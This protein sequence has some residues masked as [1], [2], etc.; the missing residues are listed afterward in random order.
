MAAAV[1]SDYLFISHANEDAVFADWLARKLMSE[2][3]RVWYDRLKL[4]G[5]E[6]YPAN[7][8]TA[9]KERS[10]R[11]LALLSAASLG[12]PNPTKERTLALNISRE[13]R[14]D[15]LIPLLV[16]PLSPTQLDWM[17]SD[18]T[19]IPFHGNWAA[20]FAALLE[21]LRSIGTPCYPDHTRQAICN[22][23]ATQDRPAE[24]PEQLWTNL[25][26]VLAMPEALRG[27]RLTGQI[28]HEELATRWPHYA[29]RDIAWAFEAPPRD[30]GITYGKPTE[31]HWPSMRDYHGLRVS[32]V[33]FHLVTRSLVTHC[34]AKGMQPQPG[35]TA[36]VYFRPE[37]LPD[38]RLRYLGYAGKQ[39]YINVTGGR[40][41]YSGGQTVT[42]RYHL[43]VRFTPA[44]WR[45]GQPF[46]QLEM[47]LY[48]TDESGQ[49]LDARVAFRRQK[50]I[51]KR[52]WNH[53][54]LSR[55]LAVSSWMADG[56]DSFNAL[57]GGLEQ[58]V[59]GARPLRVSIAC[60][61]EEDQQAPV[62]EEDGEH[63]FD[64]D[65]ELEWE[66][67]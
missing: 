8:D 36:Q 26:P 22:W 50:Q 12:K 38:S 52:W 43:A 39:T 20:G 37:L 23:M 59:V 6:S 5:G 16:E 25:L 21:K 27:F 48:L 30:L 63:A 28:D 1:D 40:K 31:I 29:H 35:H 34:L 11:L 42:N 4:L 60:G 18:L 32:D 66:E 65:S 57:H 44:L 15:F 17:T 24:R 10:F 9:I 55:L 19:Y 14:V 56:K 41:F 47:H 13:R 2:G 62:E 61:I 58:L 46:V 54:W 7:I 33:V 51:R 64:D 67:Q 45:Y 3:Y 53:E 49:E